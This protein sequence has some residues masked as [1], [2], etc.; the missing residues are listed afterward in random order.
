MKRKIK[1]LIADDD[2]VLIE[3]L[4]VQISSEDFEISTTQN[5]NS[6][7]SAIAKEDFDVILLDVN[8]PDISGLEVL[9]KLRQMNDAPEV[10][11]LTA[12]KSLKT[13]I[14]AMRHGAY[15]Y[16]TKPAEPAQ[17]EAVIRKASEKHKLVQQ[18]EQL[19]VAFRKQNENLV[20]KPVH[21][22]PPM[23]ELFKQAEKV[24][25][26]DTTILITG[27]SGTGKDVL[28]RWI[29]SQGTRSELPLI[30]VNCGAL[31][32]NLFESEFF[33]YEKGSFTGANKQKVGLIEAADGSTLFLDE[34]GEMPMTMQ[35]KLL[36]FLENGLFRRIGSTKDRQVDVRV[37]AATNKNLPEEIQNDNFRADLFYRLNVI[38]FRIPALRRRPEDIPVLINFFLK[39]LS[40][41]YKRPNLRLSKAAEKELLQHYWYGNVRELKN[42]LERTVALSTGEVINEVFG[43]NT[44]PLVKNKKSFVQEFEPISLADVEKRHILKVLDKVNGKR[45]KAAAILG[46][47]S[48]TLYRK[49]KEYDSED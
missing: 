29:H 15:D 42:T 9:S 28:A 39:K 7:I 1:I 4:P 49:L 45:E 35:V 22:S 5:G 36:H 2:P 20:V 47:T 18:N 12:D 3:L 33:G 43:L 31:P 24:A 34:I 17:V 13:G 23:K 11:M 44:Q 32:D 10:V 8:L 19:R 46:I 48:R 37:I 14:E 21:E 27:E 6:T 41:R 26:L 40:Q 30:S 25:E 38:S 16:I